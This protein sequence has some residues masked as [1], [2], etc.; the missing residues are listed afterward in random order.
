MSDR[1]NAVEV[2]PLPSHKSVGDA[3]P[4]WT[5]GNEELLELEYQEFFL[6]SWQMVGHVCDL[7]Q[8]G[9]FITLDMWRDSVIVVCGNDHVI[10]AFLNVCRHRAMRLLDG[11]G[12]CGN[13]IQCPYHG[14]TYR[15]DGSLRG[16]TQA[17]N[18][19][20][21]DKSTLGLQEI[22]L[23]IYRGHVFVNLCGGGASIDDTLGAISEAID[24]YAPETYQPHRQPTFEVWDCNWKLAWDNYQENYHIPIGHPC[25]HR[26]V[27]ST[28]EGVEFS[29]GFNFGYFAMR[30]KPSKVPQERRYQ[31]LISFTDHRFPEGKGRKWLQL[32]LDPNMGIEYYPD[33]FALFQIFPLAVDKTLVKLA[34]YSP[35]NLSAEEREL[36][37]INLALLDE[38]NDQDKMLVERIQ[39]GV[40]TTG[41]QPGPLALEESS[42]YSFH[43]RVRELIPVTRLAEAPLRGTLHQI[44][45]GLK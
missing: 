14:W 16:V 9:D 15:N 36:Q 21:L 41:Y 35:P 27:E 43:E 39:C 1:N 19:P 4:L 8:P 44:N 18:F 5:Y 42:V 28:E 13:A 34:T 31:E 22:R 37:A 38:V 10:R 2:K 29:G 40:N 7:Q 23:K 6:N 24:L 12:N 11:Q 17:E 3:L 25:L 33:L 30:D 32:A 45:A 20:D 26:M